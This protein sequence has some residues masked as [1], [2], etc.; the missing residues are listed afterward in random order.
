MHEAGLH[1]A[2]LN[3]MN[4]LIAGE[5]PGALVID[6]ETSTVETP[7][8][9]KAVI[10]NFE[11]LFRSLVKSDLYGSV[12]EFRQVVRFARAYDSECWRD[13]I[14]AGERRYRRTAFLHRISWWLTGSRR[15]FPA[16]P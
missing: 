1:H 5:P 9:K 4:L 12:V 14:R 13:L 16:G 8:S 6:L 10:S 15:L 7:I 11:R 2:D 3:L